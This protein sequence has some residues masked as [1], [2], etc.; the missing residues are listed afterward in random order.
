VESYK[1]YF[2]IF[3]VQKLELRFFQVSLR[4]KSKKEKKTENPLCMSAP[5]VSTNCKQSPPGPRPLF[6]ES[7]EFCRKTPRLWLNRARDPSSTSEHR[8]G[9]TSVRSG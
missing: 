7:M 2:A 3:R 9:K 5:W 8:E 4:I 1:N 6:S